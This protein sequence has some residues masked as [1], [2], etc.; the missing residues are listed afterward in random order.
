MLDFWR[1][2]Q[3]LTPLYQGDTTLYDYIFNYSFLLTT[4]IRIINGHFKTQT[5][6]PKKIN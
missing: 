3:T 2:L 5:K 6:N 1:N 4:K